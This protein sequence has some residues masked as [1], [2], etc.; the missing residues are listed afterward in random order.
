MVE[1][2]IETSV[3]EVGV[4]A[5]LFAR[6]SWPRILAE[7]IVIVSSILLAFAVDAW[8]D[9]RND[10]LEEARVLLDLSF[11][12][13]E[14]RSRLEQVNAQHKK[15][16]ERAAII[17]RES[18]A[19]REGLS[20]DSLRQL[21][22]SVFI[23]PVFDSERGVIASVLSSNGLALIRDAEL[24]AELAGFWDR[25]DYYF[26]NQRTIVEHALFTESTF[27]GT[28]SLVN[29]RIPR[30]AAM[31]PS[32]M[33]SSKLTPEEVTAVKYFAT[34]QLVSE[35]LANQGES[36]LVALDSMIRRVSPQD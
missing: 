29:P 13:Q 21:S 11:E 24:R 35:L 3:P 34:V 1:A 18:G 6:L 12:F 23:N 15:R 2:E 19:S 22:D 14:N 5:H 27:F 10:R 28:G 33:W 16:G 20:S 30:T 9:R 32:I 36:L 17:V 25:F 8:W 26:T 31:G 4:R 7:S